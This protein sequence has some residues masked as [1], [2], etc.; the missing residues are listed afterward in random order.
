ICP[1]PEVEVELELEFAA[2]VEEEDSPED[3]ADDAF[4]VEEVVEEAEGEAC[5]VVELADVAEVVVRCGEVTTYAAPN[6]TRAAMTAVAAICV[7]LAP[8]LFKNLRSPRATGALPS[9]RSP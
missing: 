9:R 3:V 1:E 8:F 6:K 2:L 5:V 4:V 7:L